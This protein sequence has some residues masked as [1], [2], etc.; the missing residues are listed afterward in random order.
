MDLIKI[1]DHTYYTPCDHIT[2]RPVLGLV[3]GEE[4]SV[5][6]DAGN[7]PAHAAQYDVAVKAQ[8]LPLPKFCVITHWHWDHT[9]GICA[10]KE[11]KRCTLA[12]E[13]TNRELC[14]MAKW[15]WDDASMR[16]RLEDGE[17]ISFADE[18]IRA[19]YADTETIRVLPADI[20]FKDSVTID[21]GGV[22]CRCIH[23]PSAHSED[24]VVV[25]VP[26]ERIVFI[27]D[28]YGDDFFRDNYRD[29]EKTRA[30]Y[31]ALNA[32]EADLVVPGHGEPEKKDRILE[33]LEGFLK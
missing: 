3:C 1:T 10:L 20:T 12:H 6:V 33:Y 5:M 17:E 16:A 13:N 14:R 25:F 7:S 21:C 22:T 29:L 26:E 30:L 28:I 18:H 9:Y 31:D 4:F 15:A 19:E 27:G 8:G 11:K 24:S 32:M 23:L 2:D